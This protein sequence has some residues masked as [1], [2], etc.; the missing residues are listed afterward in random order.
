MSKGD[1]EALI[2][3]LLRDAATSQAN[4]EMLEGLQRYFNELRE[5]R[6]SLEEQNAELAALN[7][8][9]ARLQADNRDLS[10]QS[11]SQILELQQNLAL[12]KSQADK[13]LSRIK[14]FEATNNELKANVAK[15]EARLSKASDEL[16]DYA[17]VMGEYDTLQK[18]NEKFQQENENLRNS[19][20]YI[21]E[22]ARNAHNALEA[23]HARMAEKLNQLQA[24]A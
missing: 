1:V 19:I 3:D 7:E 4:S 22:N 14:E 17:N 16:I 9:V 12:S 21:I 24:N 6:A 20:A 10:D 13:R 8:N 23:S 11:T 5:A 2:E 15:L 18:E